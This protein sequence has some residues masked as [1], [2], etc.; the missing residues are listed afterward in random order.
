MNSSNTPHLGFGLGLRPKHY[1]YIFEHKPNIDWFEIIS[2]N[3]MD[4]DGR[5]KRNLA[6]MK[7]LYPIVMHGVSMSI[8]TADPLNSEYLRKLKKLIQWLKPAW[9]SDHLCWTGVAHKNTHDL[10][11]VPYTEEAL[12]HIVGRIKQV[13]SYLEIPIA[14]E[15]PSTYLEFKTSE[16]GEAEFIREMC[17]ESGCNL[18]L[19]VNNVYVTCYNHNLD[20]KKYIDSL[21]LEKVIQ[22]HL[23]GHTNNGTHIIDTHDGHV[24]DEVW[25][26]YKYV[27]SKLGY[28]PNTMLEW[29][30]NIPEFRTLEQE[31]DKARSF[32][33]SPND[34]VLPNLELNSSGNDGETAL[35]LTATQQRMQNAILLGKSFDSAPESWIINKSE[36]PSQAQLNVYINAYRYR[37]IDVVAEDYPALAEYLGY[38]TFRDLIEEFVNTERSTHFNIARYSWKLPKFIQGK[39]PDDLFAYELSMLESSILEAHDAAETEALS[40]THIA[41]ITPDVFMDSILYPRKS[42]KLLRFKHDVNQYYQD[43]MDEKKPTPR[44]LKQ[45]FLGVFRHEDFVWRIRLDKI[46]YA[47]LQDLFKG[48]SICQALESVDEEAAHKLSDYFAKWM[49][50]GLLSSQIDNPMS[51]GVK[52]VSN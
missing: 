12:K 29:D 9:I 33:A 7:E 45:I 30:D 14:L 46:E 25:N 6:K 51:Q 18:L 26:I 17:I 11:P 21:P 3:F 48:K 24:V 44:V 35:T 41:N 1:P 10:L 28:T 49:R 31:L 50:N 40:Q 15:N 42:L 43:V 34:Y 16:M 20:V 13:Q 27:V 5:P 22:M 32:A 36:F 8:G 19:D 23:A 38:E 39:L 37:L 52:N 2:E 4:T 47:I